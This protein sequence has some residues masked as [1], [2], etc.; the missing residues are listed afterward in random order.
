MSQIKA[1]GKK[2]Q[3]KENTL[4]KITTTINNTNFVFPLI[5]HI[6]V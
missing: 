4:V 3:I 2:E 5:Y 6:N 1:R